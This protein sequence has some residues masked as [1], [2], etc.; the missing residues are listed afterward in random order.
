MATKSFK[1][2]ALGI[3]Y[4]TVSAIPISLTRVPYVHHGPT[5]EIKSVLTDKLLVKNT[6]KTLTV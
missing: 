4:K 2:E 5:Q 3:F 1:G 6:L